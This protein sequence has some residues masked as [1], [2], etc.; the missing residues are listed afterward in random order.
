MFCVFLQQDFALEPAKRLLQNTC[1]NTKVHSLKLTWPWNKCCTNGAWENKIP[2][3][4]VT[5]PV[6]AFLPW[7][8]EFPRRV[9]AGGEPITLCQALSFAALPPLLNLHY[10]GCKIWANW[11]V[12]GI[13]GCFLLST[14]WRILW[15]NY[16]TDHYTNN[17]LYHWSL[18]KYLNPTC[19]PCQLF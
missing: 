14:R 8:A 2:G 6:R 13:S 9:S 19:L 5:F 7:L 12:L 16:T 4:L 3:R 18:Y 10:H 15:T 11:N 1:R 17:K